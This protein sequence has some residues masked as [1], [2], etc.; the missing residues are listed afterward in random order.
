MVTTLSSSYIGAGGPCVTLG[1]VGMWQ[2]FNIYTLSYYPTYNPNL[3]AAFQITGDCY[4]LRLTG[5]SELNSRI[6]YSRYVIYG[7][8]LDIEAPQDP[9][10]GVSRIWLDG[11]APDP[12]GG[13][14][15]PA[16]IAGSVRVNP[17]SGISS[18]RATRTRACWRAGLGSRRTRTPVWL[19][20]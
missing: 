13:V 5:S 1:G 19:V 14:L 3:Y 12:E 8:E 17:L 16:I 18:S 15:V 9:A 11:Q 7:L 20:G 4:S 10:P 6:L 2:G